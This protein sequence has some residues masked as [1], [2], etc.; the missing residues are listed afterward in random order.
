M[1]VSKH[2]TLYVAV[3]ATENIVAEC[4]RLDQRLAE[5]NHKLPQGIKTASSLPA[6]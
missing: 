1:T 6:A 5:L 4:K 3:L 2:F